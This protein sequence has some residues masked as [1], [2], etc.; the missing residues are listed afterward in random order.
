M[1]KYKTNME[2]EVMRKNTEITRLNQVMA[3]WIHKYMDLQ[4]LT[5]IPSEASGRLSSAYLGELTQL[6]SK[7]K[8]SN[9]SE[10]PPCDIDSRSLQMR[11]RSNPVLSP[12][13][14]TQP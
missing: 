6:I 13:G 14:D 12:E 4:E 8:Q 11:W 2:T 9:P 5:G 1:D 3:E 7:T 10:V